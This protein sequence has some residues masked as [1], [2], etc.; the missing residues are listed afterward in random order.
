MRHRPWTSLI[1]AA[2][3]K[4]HWLAATTLFLLVFGGLEWAALAPIEAASHNELFTIP[5][6]T[7]ARRMAGEKIEILP[8]TIRLMLGVND[9]LLLRNADVV[10][11]VFGPTL[12]M[13]GQSFSLPFAQASI[14]SF[15]CTAHANGQL[16]VIVEP[17]PAPGRER[18]RWRLHRLTDTAWRFAQLPD[19]RNYRGTL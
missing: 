7:W 19:W 6:G 18:L 10:P 14:Y 17:L 8:H 11:H 5:R 9:I 15:M 13:P 16:N 2:S 4:R 3:R 1:S 12:I